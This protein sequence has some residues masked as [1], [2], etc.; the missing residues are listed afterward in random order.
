MLCCVVLHDAM[1]GTHA[2][3]QGKTQVLLDIRE[4]FSWFS[5]V[6]TSSTQR[7]LDLRTRTVRRI[8]KAAVGQESSRER[9]AAIEISDDACVLMAR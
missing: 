2:T 1:H 3:D 5:L 9:Q 8:M 4:L 7:F 6:I